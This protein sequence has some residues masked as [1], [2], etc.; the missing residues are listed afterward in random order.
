MNAPSSALRAPS[1]IGK[2]Q[3]E[4]A[5]VSAFARASL[6]MGIRETLRVSSV[7]ADRRMRAS[8]FTKNANP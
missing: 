8:C 3:Q 4:K 6:G 2:D 7:G 5:T 1:P